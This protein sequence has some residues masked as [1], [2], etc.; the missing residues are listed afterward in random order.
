LVESFALF[1]SSLEKRVKHTEANNSQPAVCTSADVVIRK[2]NQ[3][4]RGGMPKVGPQQHFHGKKPTNTVDGTMNHHTLGNNGSTSP[5]R[6]VRLRSLDLRGWQLS[7]Q[8]S[9]FLLLATLSLSLLP[10]SVSSV[11]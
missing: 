4:E 2:L 11:L 9:A 10:E 1:T 6:S 7:V 3:T 8:F 5:I